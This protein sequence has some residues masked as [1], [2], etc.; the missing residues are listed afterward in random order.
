MRAHACVVPVALAGAALAFAC[1][2]SSSGAACQSGDT[3]QCTCD[4]GATGTKTCSGNQFGACV[5]SGTVGDGGHEGGPSTSDAG[6][7]QYMGSCEAAADCPAGDL[8]NA[9][10]SKGNI[11]THACDSGAQCE[12]PSPRCN[13]RGLCAVPD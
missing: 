7:G 8:C 10:P 11:C 12:P 5:C 9:F 6:F 13:P 2:T 3:Q 1:S 4:G